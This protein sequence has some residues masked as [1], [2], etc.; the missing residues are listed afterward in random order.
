MVINIPAQKIIE[1]MEEELLHLS[2]L[3][4]GDQTEAVQAHARV[5]RAYCDL[6]LDEETSKPTKNKT[7]KQPRVGSDIHRLS[8]KEISSPSIPQQDK[9]IPSTD[10]NLLEF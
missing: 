4:E 6:L 1:K 10:G 3:S 8:N 5:L 2:E 9:D 7:A